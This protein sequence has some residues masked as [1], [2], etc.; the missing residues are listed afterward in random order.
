MINLFSYLKKYK[1]Q[2]ILAPLF[3]MFEAILELFVPLIMADIIDYGI[4]NNDINYII[5]K[6]I[7]LV[8]LAIGGVAISIT[9]QY[10]SAK[11]A[12][13]TATE[14]RL[15]LFSHIEKLSFKEIDEIGTS[16]LITRLTSDV[17]QFQTGINMGLRLLLR[18]PFI[19]IGAM[20][21]AFV[22]SPKQAMIFVFIIPVLAIIVFSLI[23][24]TKPLYQKIQ[25]KLDRVLKLTRENITGNRVIR[26]F[27]L[28]DSEIDKYIDSSTKLYKEERHG[29]IFSN[30]MNPLTYV[31]INLGIVAIIYFSEKP[32]YNGELTQGQVVALYNYMSQILVELIKLGNLVVTISKALASKKRIEN[33][34]NTKSSQ[35][36]KTEDPKILNDIIEFKNVSFCYSKSSIK[37]LENINFKAKQGDIIGIIGPTGSGKTTLI[38]LLSR[39][40]DCSEGEI[41][42]YGNNINEYSKDFLRNNIGNVLQKASLFQGTLRENLL[43]GNNDASDDEINQALILACAKNIVDKKEKGLDELITQNGKNLSGGEKQRLSIA[44]T[45]LKRPKIIIFD[46]SSS[47]LDYLTEYTLRQ[48]L[49]TL[50]Y[51]PLVIIVSQRA[52]SVMHADN[53]LVLEDGECVGIGT[54]NELLKNCKEYIEIY[55]SQYEIK[56][57][58]DK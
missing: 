18:S 2:A 53:I 45:L 49:K 55:N 35:F 48:N 41:L 4:A 26:A 57:K 47:A 36:F 32:V 11:A 22:V 16:T 12:V 5:I 28:E 1:W 50:D 17:N 40:Y 8:L 31:I 52:A 23:F 34:L 13:G 38:S 24:L 27:A 19:V 30:L 7:L 29:G 25:S 37:S 58:E 56:S 6:G 15:E 21:M 10:F 3:K 46:D 43:W 33:I 20:I 39:F 42:L 9:A 54:H 44:R 51:K 14:V